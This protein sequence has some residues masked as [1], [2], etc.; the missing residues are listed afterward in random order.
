MANSRIISEKVDEKGFPYPIDHNP[1]LVRP[2]SIRYYRYHLYLAISYHEIVPP[3]P[4]I[5][6]QFAHETPVFSLIQG[7]LCHCI[8]WSSYT[9][10]ART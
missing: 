8:V 6:P 3:T 2:L 4:F 5:F 10:H 1:R 9:F 7:A